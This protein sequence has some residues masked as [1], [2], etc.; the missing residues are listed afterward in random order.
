MTKIERIKKS[1]K[2][3]DES[4]LDEL[5]RIAYYLG[6]TEAVREV[7]DEHSTILKAAHDKANKLRYR[8]MARSILPE[9]NIIYHSDYAGDYPFE[10]G[11]DEYRE[12][13]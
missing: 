11:S 5:I 4:E 12:D 1:I 7:C 10:F 13:N 3:W 9:S 6:R 2:D 8:H